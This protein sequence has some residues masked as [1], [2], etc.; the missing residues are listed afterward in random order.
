MLMRVAPH[1]TEVAL[2]R[3]VMP[4][5]RSRSFESITRSAT[6]WL[7]RKAPD[8]CRSL[9]TSVVLP[10]S[11]W[12]MMATLRSFI[13]DG[14][15]KAVCG[16]GGAFLMREDDRDATGR[17][18]APSARRVAGRIPRKVAGREGRGAERLKTLA[19]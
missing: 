11:T 8:C 2:A 1:T 12:A 15:Q 14:S 7:S 3:M 10:W 18:G 5:S 19:G 17:D 4:R 6:R 13:R 9:S 16:G